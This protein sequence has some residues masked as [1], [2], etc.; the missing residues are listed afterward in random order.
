M[1]QGTARWEGEEQHQRGQVPSPYKGRKLS[2]CA[3]SVPC[4][5]RTLGTQHPGV[6]GPRQGAQP[7]CAGDAVHICSPHLSLYTWPRGRNRCPGAGAH[8]CAGAWP[9]SPLSGAVS[10]PSPP[11]SVA[12]NPQFP[13]AQDPRHRGNVS[14]GEQT[15]VHRITKVNMLRPLAPGHRCLPGP[16]PGWQ[17][18]GSDPHLHHELPF[19]S[20]NPQP[21]FWGGCTSLPAAQHFPVRA[22]SPPSAAPPRPSLSVSAAAG[23]NPSVRP[24]KGR[25]WRRAPAPGSGTGPLGLG[26]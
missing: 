12:F 24:G 20:T 5:G 10:L 23:T 8:P 26:R 25:R 7:R 9:G 2:P 22:C 16:S 21:G 13:R 1:L 4:R 6:P 3:R 19:C 11:L 18:G 14:A 15:L 17:Q